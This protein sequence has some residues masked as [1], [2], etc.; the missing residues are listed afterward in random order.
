MALTGNAGAADFLSGAAGAW[1]GSGTARASPDAAEEPLRCRIENTYDERTG[2]LSIE[3]RCA[4]PGRI[5]KIQGH[6]QAPQ[7]DH[8]YSARWVNPQGVGSITMRGRA[9]KDAIRFDYVTKDADSGERTKG[10]MVWHF[11]TDSLTIDNYIV[12]G[13]RAE[14]IGNT[15]FSR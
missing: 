9:D 14:L 12:S 7:T 10:I 6:I 2:R 4:A 5:I 8:I 13:G 1:T 11:K 15:Q 3:G